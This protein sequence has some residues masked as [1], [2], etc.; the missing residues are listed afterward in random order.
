MRARHVFVLGTF[1]AL[2]VS[3]VALG[4]VREAP[5]G[6]IPVDEI[7]P[8]MRGY[9]LTVFRGTT[10]ERFDV[11]VIDV[12]H[13]FRP[14]QDLI[15]VRTEHPILEQANVVAGMSGSPVYFDGRLAGAY[16]YGWPFSNAP[17]AGVTPMRNILVE[18]RRPV[19][20]NAFP[21]ANP[22]PQPRGRR[23][24]RQSSLQNT[25]SRLA[26]LPPYLGERRITATSALDAHVE[27]VGPVSTSTTTLVPAATPLLV[28]G[29]DDAT[30]RM[31]GEQL[32]DFGMM[33]LQ[34]GGGGTQTNTP[35]GP[36]PSYAHGSAVG[37]QLVRGDV[38][39]TAVGTVTHV[40]GNRVGAFGHP[41]MNAGET[42]LPTAFSRVLH[43]LTSTQRS[44][45]IAEPVVSLGALVQDRQSAIV[46]DT[47]VHPAT[48]PLTVRVTGI[49]HAPRSEWNM[50]VASHRVL[51]PVLVNAAI[52]SA[53]GA[54]ASDATD[55][56][57]VAT[58]RVWVAG[59]AQPIEVVDR[60]YSRAGATS[61]LALGSIRLFNI[62]EILYGNPFEDARAER[63]EVN[64]DLSFA[65]DTIRIIDAS[66]AAREVDPGSVVP[67]RVVLRRFDESEEVRTVPVSIPAHA[68]GQTIEIS[69]T[70]G[71]TVDVVTLQPRN[72]EELLSTVHAQY[73]STSLV[74]SLEMQSRGLRFAGHVVDHL[75]PSALDSLQLRNDGD[76]NRPFVT[77]ERR[78]LPMGS[79]IV[80]GS[81]RVELA[82]RR[83]PR[84]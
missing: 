30:V 19:Q 1:A 78:E 55:M 31:L 50:E 35:A 46:V 27:R 40:D 84:P 66:I 3:A 22:L 81:A 77:Y 56:M 12:L 53:L 82:V 59:R 17:V 28:G 14:D 24:R 42:G 65:H 61:P 79:S 25:T 7:R 69:I 49:P 64:L 54:T 15:L 67:V 16:A 11:E 47:D 43:V 68:A 83:R 23:G 57:Y 48:V 58:S 45:K 34:V 2:L 71:A 52:T 75:P 36:P 72:L 8:G 13:N 51:T 10:P 20:P 5:S 70:S 9:G 74:V 39:M 73:P 6:I 29:L 37:V 62:L 38:S 33:V 44:F 21:T 18:M 76:R 80:S 63:V 26:G 32:D 60:G 41:M 4:Q